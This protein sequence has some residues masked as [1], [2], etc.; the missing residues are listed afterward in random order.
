MSDKKNILTH[1]SSLITHHCFMTEST[2][3]YYRSM[4][5]ARASRPTGRTWCPA[6][7]VLEV[8]DGWVVK[9][10]LAGVAP[11]EVEISID[12]RTLN[13]TGTRRDVAYGES[14]SYYQMEITYSRFHKQLRFPCTIK[15]VSVERVSRHGLLVLHLQR[16]EDCGEGAA[17][18]ASET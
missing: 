14:I 16:Q 5:V 6:A 17:D 3:R 10:E 12:D 15:D 8:R 11:D 4:P 1:H 7:D 9:L 2:D 13:V 18:K